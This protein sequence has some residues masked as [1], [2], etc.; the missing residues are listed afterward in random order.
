MPPERMFH[1]YK[2]Q[3]TACGCPSPPVGEDQKGLKRKKTKTET[4]RLP[5]GVPWMTFPNHSEV[6]DI[7]K[8]ILRAQGQIL[9]S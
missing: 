4:T 5:F 6:N 2:S 1:T 8:L 7:S 9:L 3:T